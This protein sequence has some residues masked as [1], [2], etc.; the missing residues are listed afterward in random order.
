MLR[1]LGLAKIL[2]E[3][4]GYHCEYLKEIED[5]LTKDEPLQFPLPLIEKKMVKSKRRKE[6]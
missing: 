6:K 2:F 4:Q 5:E 3:D 1:A